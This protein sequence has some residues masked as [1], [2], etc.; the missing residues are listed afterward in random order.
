[1][2]DDSPEAADG[3]LNAGE[4]AVDGEVYEYPFRVADFH[5]EVIRDDL[6]TIP[7]FLNQMEIDVL[8][9]ELESL[10]EDGIDDG[11][12]EQTLV[13]VLRKLPDAEYGRGALPAWIV[14]ES[15][16]CEMATDGGEPTVEQNPRA[17]AL[18]PNASPAEATAGG[19]AIAGEVVLSWVVEQTASD[20]HYRIVVA[21]AGSGWVVL[22]QKRRGI[23]SEWNTVE[24]HDASEKPRLVAMKGV[25]DDD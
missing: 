25:G 23:N 16:E 19:D 22:R 9:S 24:T 11:F 5:G 10:F 20:L 2:S 15:D 13:E 12:R 8:A 3:G 21:P 17:M 14:K 18:I 1:M 7:P 6:D 4:Q